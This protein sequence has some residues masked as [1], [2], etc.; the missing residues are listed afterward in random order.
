MVRA[1]WRSVS[2]LLRAGG[3]TPVICRVRGRFVLLN[4]LLAVV[5]IVDLLRMD[6]TATRGAVFLLAVL[7]LGWWSVALAA[8]HGRSALLGVVGP[9]LVAVAGIAAAGPQWV[10]GRMY[11][12]LLLHSLYGSRRTVYSFAA[13]HLIAFEAAVVAAEGP[14]GLLSVQLVTNGVAVVLLAYV[15]HT[16]TGAVHRLDAV[17]DREATLTGAS[18]GLLTARRPEEVTR[19]AVGAVT[20]LLAEQGAVHV[21][22]WSERGDR[23]DVALLEGDEL[24]TTSVSVHALPAHLV[25]RYRIGELVRVGPWETASIG[26]VIGVPDWADHGV[27]VPVFDGQRGT[28]LVFIASAT[29]LDDDVVAPLARFLHEVAFAGQLVRRTALLSGVVDNS[30]D[31]I[32]LI[33]DEGVITFASPSVAALSGRA[34]SLAGRPIGHLLWRSADG[35]T[36]PVVGL[37]DLLAGD[38]AGLRLPSHELGL[39]Q[40]EVT[41]NRV[42]GVGTV[43]NVRDVTERARL[44]AEIAYRAFHDPVTELPNR[45]LF[46][47]RLVH[48]L[49]RAG[50]EDAQVAV[51]L[52]DLDD[53]KGVNDTLGHAAGDELLQTVGR[54]LAGVLRTSDT[55]ARLGGDEFA[56]LLEGF[57]DPA[58]AE[59]AVARALTVLREPVV[60]CGEELSVSASVGIRTGGGDECAED[61]LGDADVAMYV[62]KAGGKDGVASFQ[63]TMRRAAVERRALHAQLAGA[64]ERDELL[65][66]FQ[67]I[68]DLR[69]GVPIGLEALV[70]WIHPEQGLIPPDRFIPLAE[71]TGLIVGIGR[72]VLREA[73]RQLAVWRTDGRVADDLHISVNLS[74]RQLLDV[75][76]VAEVTAALADTGTP[77]CHLVLEVTETALMEEPE[78]AGEALTALSAIGVQVA[79]DDFGTGYSSFA[80]LQ[81]FPVDVLKVDRSFVQAATSGDDQA[82]L[83]Q[84]I[85]ALATTL[86]IETVAEGVEEEIHRDLLASWG[87]G[88][89]QGWL[90]APALPAAEVPGWLAGHAPAPAV[91]ALTAADRA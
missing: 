33:D 89:G 43:A 6:V 8:D 73:C 11:V 41:L 27:A 78:R 14:A 22:L 61:L 74:A 15:M 37:E 84:A 23:F 42:D 63:S 52:L 30:A 83:A 49:Q 72:W 58:E 12:A 91:A 3:D 87:C 70:R 79:I 69:R 20:R 67:P 57:V 56:L 71:E 66:H 60:L 90:W 76:L 86:G 48:A 80:Y 40:V 18:T 75:D 53:F 47:D 9:A 24:V 17:V 25:T 45:A 35:S 85:V 28:G 82:S 44:E 64:I 38:P 2:A 26:R 7:A 62:A 29:L 88:F 36:R 31:G 10:S 50:R 34:E 32:L 4:L 59:A 68:L 81:R 65:L 1:S 54:R 13:L 19:T 77:P 21:T 39:L 16:L 51:A 55:V 5:G 46:M